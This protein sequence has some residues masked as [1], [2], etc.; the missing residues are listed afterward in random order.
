MEG[1]VVFQFAWFECTQ[2]L[3]DLTALFQVI[4]QLYLVFEI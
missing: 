1:I 2:E 3:F 4:T